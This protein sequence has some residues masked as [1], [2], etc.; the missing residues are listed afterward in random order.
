MTWTSRTSWILFKSG[1]VAL[2]LWLFPGTISLPRGGESSV[3]ALSF[4]SDVIIRFLLMRGM[5]S[6]GSSGAASLRPGLP[7]HLAGAGCPKS[8]HKVGRV[9]W[10]TKGRSCKRVFIQGPHSRIQTNS[11]GIPPESLRSAFLLAGPRRSTAS[12]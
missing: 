5:R 7:R 11:A 10:M 8:L 1:L 12:R 6:H 4:S 9:M 2:F 3:T